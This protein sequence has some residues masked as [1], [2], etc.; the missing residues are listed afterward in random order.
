MTELYGVPDTLKDQMIPDTNK[1]FYIGHSNGG[2][3]A[4]WL[5]THRPDTAL[6]AMPA[7]GYI[8]TQMYVPQYM[9][10]GYS[11]VDPVIRGVT[12]SNDQILEA[13]ISEND[14]D[15][16]ASNIA[17]IPILARSGALDDN[18]PPLHSRRMMRIIDEWNCDAH[19][20]EYVLLT[21]DTS[22]MKERAIGLK[23]CSEMKLH[24][25]S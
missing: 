23:V 6:G 24:K 9:H 25:T 17:G 11:Y 8:K 20:V 12:T 15:L 13:S 7:A 5:A 3:G 1:L 19:S 4:W 21:K 22:R 2:H 18:V 14:I 16:Y 10:I